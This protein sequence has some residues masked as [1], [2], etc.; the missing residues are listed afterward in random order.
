MSAFLTLFKYE[1]KKQFPISLNFKKHKFDV[2]GFLLSAIITVAIAGLFI[3]FLSVVGKSYVAIKINKVLDSKARVYEL[4]NVLYVITLIPMIFICLENM[5]RTLCDKADKNVLLP[6]PVKEQTLF[7]SKFAVL[8]LKTYIM[9]LVLIVPVNAIVYSAFLPS[10]IFWLT[11]FIVWLIFPTIVFMFA[12]LFIVPYIKIFN[13]MKDKYILIFIL[14]TVVLAIFVFL[15]SLFLGATQ[16]Y[17]ETGQIKFLFNEEFIN[18]LKFM[19][20]WF[21]PVN[22]LAGIV[23]CT[24]LLKSILVVVGCVVISALLIY[25]IATKLFHLTLYKDD[26]SKVVYKKSTKTKQLPVLLTLIKKEFLT[27]AREPKHIFSYLAIATIMP[28]L[29]YCCFTLFES[30]IL[31]MLGVNMSLPLALFIMLVF[32][33]LTNTFCSTN[34]SREG[35]FFQ[36][37]KTLP[38]KPANILFSKVIFCCMVSLLSVLLTAI[39]LIASTSLKFLDGMFC[40]LLSSIFAISQILLATKMDLK[41]AKYGF[42]KDQI[43]RRSSKTI[44]KVV[45]LGLLISFIT[46][47]AT[48]ALG[49]ISDKLF[50]S[51][52]NLNVCF[53]YLVPLA[54]SLIYVGLATWYYFHKIENSFESV[55][56]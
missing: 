38:I 11:S 3:Y 28:I 50:I 30:L 51:K 16:G 13:F 19:L 49:L 41:C 47:F 40:L 32:G 22:C 45:A 20:N 39:V 25:F 48:L 18:A 31:N 21:Y 42:S 53:V 36:K 46:G 23:L 7:L 1:L 55:K 8:L 2:L 9:A 26:V 14:L 44:A 52:F 17:L 43:E 35:V 10:G 6:L 29:V 5:R 24:D 33:V 34:I 54:I 12:C 15:Y 4:L 37:I 27:I 56:I